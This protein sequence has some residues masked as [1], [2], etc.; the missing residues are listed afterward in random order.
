LVATDG[1][2]PTELGVDRATLGACGLDGKVGQYL[3]L[4]ASDQTVRVAVGVGAG[5][6]SAIR[7]RRPD[8]PQGERIRL[9]EAL[10][11]VEEKL[12][13][14]LAGAQAESAEVG[15]QYARLIAEA[16]YMQA[17]RQHLASLTPWWAR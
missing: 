8:D 9:S 15:E 17:V 1:P 12:G 10:R 3:V 6:V 13:Y 7:R 4:P 16:R 11:D 2:V 14:W 5:A